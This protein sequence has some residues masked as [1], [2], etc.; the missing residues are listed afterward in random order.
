M[1]AVATGMGAPSER[2]SVR[3]AGLG[4]HPETERWIRDRYGRIHPDDTFDD[5]KRR[6]A[7]SRQDAGLLRDWIKAARRAAPEMFPDEECL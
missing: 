3:R 6:A 2:P 1:G 7:F 4:L 5:L